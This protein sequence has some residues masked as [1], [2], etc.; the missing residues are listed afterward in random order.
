[1]D[2]YIRKTDAETRRHI[3]KRSGVVVVYHGEDQENNQ[4]KIQDKRMEE[5]Q[6]GV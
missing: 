5:N 6:E 2:L 3:V 4:K 1:M